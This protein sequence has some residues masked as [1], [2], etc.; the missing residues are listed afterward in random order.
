[1]DYIYESNRI[2]AEQ[3]DYL[4]LAEIVFPNRDEKRVNLDHVYVDQSLRG[5]GVASELMLLAYNYIKSKNLK[6]VAKCPYAITW[7]K[8]HVEFQDIVINVKTKRKQ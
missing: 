7:F 5:K 6:I 1:M 4:L 8:R 2:Y 3:E